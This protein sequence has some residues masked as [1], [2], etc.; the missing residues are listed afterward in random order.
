MKSS[1]EHGNG[2]SV[3][4]AREEFIDRLSHYWL[5]RKDIISR[6]HFVSIEFT[7]NSQRC[8]LSA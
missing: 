5:L 1:G 4:A 8:S 2:P 6:C 3:D 7:E